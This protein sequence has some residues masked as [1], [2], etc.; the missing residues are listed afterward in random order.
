MT[1]EEKSRINWRDEC[2][3][4]TPLLPSETGLEVA[5]YLDDG[6]AAKS[7]HHPVVVF[8]QNSYNEN[9]YH[10]RHLICITADEYA[11]NVFNTPLRIRHE[12]YMYVRFWIARNRDLIHTLANRDIDIFGF[13]RMYNERNTKRKMVAESVEALNEMATIDGKMFGIPFGIWIDNNQ[14]WRDAGHAARVK[15]QTT[16]RSKNTKNWNPMMLHNLEFISAAK[17]AK[18]YSSKEIK[19]IKEFIKANFEFI[20]TVTCGEQKYKTE[21]ILAG[22]LTMDEIRNKKTKQTINAGIRKLKFLNSLGAK[23]EY[24]IVY[25]PDIN[26]YSVVITSTQENAVNNKWFDAILPSL[27]TIGDENFIEVFLDNKIVTVKIKNAK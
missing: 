12:D 10:F 6:Y 19:T 14:T 1:Q 22:L 13:M 9:D 3:Q 2:E 17:D 23:G 27:K 11:Q 8:V 16:N 20:K 24:K 18:N 15:I 7:N 21:E 4:F 5:I 26:Q 25:D